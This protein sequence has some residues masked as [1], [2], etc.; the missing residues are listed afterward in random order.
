[1]ALY[2][3]E[4]G[5]RDRAERLLRQVAAVT[6]RMPTGFGHLLGVLDLF[7]TP[8]QEIALVAD[9]DSPAGAGMLRA[10]FGRYLPGKVVALVHPAATPDPSLRLLADRKPLDGQPTAWV[11]R[12]FHCERPVT[13]PEALAAQ[14]SS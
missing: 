13:T 1:M 10:I 4:A 9:P 12:H 8:V 6:P 11:C 14:L 7:L 2:T 5:Y 3:G